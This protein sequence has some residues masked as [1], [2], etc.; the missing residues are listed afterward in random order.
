MAIYPKWRHYPLWRQP[1]PWVQEVVE[2]FASLE[3]EISSI[4]THLTSNQ[5]LA[6]VRLRFSEL[7]FLI[8]GAGMIRRPVLFGD[9]GVPAKSFNVDGFRERDGLAL[10]VESGGAMYNNRVILDLVKMCL[11]VDA[12]GGIVALPI[13]YETERKRWT[14]PYVG[15]VKLLD[16]VFA[17]PDR[18]RVPLEGFLLLGY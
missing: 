15:G 18:F 8:E 14:D 1:S 2:A 11:A 4:S 6:R 16:A 13:R 9:E 17:N 7:G 10:E 5:A 3:A 12:R